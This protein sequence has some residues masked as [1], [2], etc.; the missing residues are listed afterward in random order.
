MCNLRQW[1]NVIKYYTITNILIYYILS[2][3]YSST[4]YFLVM[5]LYASTLYISEENTVPFTPP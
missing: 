4:E 3:I 1:W 5:Q 2:T